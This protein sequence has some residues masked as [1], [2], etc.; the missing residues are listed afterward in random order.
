MNAARQAQL[1]WLFFYRENLRDQE[2]LSLFGHNYFLWFLL[3]FGLLGFLIFMSVIVYGLANAAKK[4]FI[5]RR[6]FVLATAV[7]LAAA[8]FLGTLESPLGGFLFGLLLFTTAKPESQVYS[9][10]EE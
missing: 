1:S 10:V 3:K 7:L 5:L 6:H 2:R 4:S 9:K 8:V